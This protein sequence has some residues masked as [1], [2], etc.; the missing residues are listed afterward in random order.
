ME[1]REQDQ[2]KKWLAFT[3]AKYAMDTTLTAVEAEEQVPEAERNYH[4]DLNREAWEAAK[5]TKKDLEARQKA[6]N[7]RLEVLA[8]KVKSATAE[9]E[10]A[11][12]EVKKWTAKEELA[13][14]EED[15]DRMNATMFALNEK[16]IAIQRMMRATKKMEEAIK[17]QQ[18]KAGGGG[19]GGEGEGGEGEGGDI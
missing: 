4:N 6:A 8:A 1:E 3:D 18:E 17:A 7:E 11:K 14:E 9:L 2:R 19:G 13:T 12:A 16:K 15:D 10:W 5:K